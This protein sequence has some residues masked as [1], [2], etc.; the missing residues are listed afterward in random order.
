MKLPNTAHTS[1]PW[2]IHEIAGEP[3]PT[4]DLPPKSQ[5][6]AS[7]RANRTDRTPP[8]DSPK[9]DTEPH[10]P[11]DRARPHQ[12]GRG[13]RATSEKVETAVH[14]ANPVVVRAEPLSA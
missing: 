5:P 2:R 9:P 3:D 14:C 6:A 11:R 1:R 13:L 12:H 10:I 7:P 8:P 4:V